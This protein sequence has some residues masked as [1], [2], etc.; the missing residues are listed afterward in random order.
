[1]PRLDR[2]ERAAYMQKYNMKKT[3]EK[4]ELKPPPPPKQPPPPCPTPNFNY[5]AWRQCLVTV[6]MW[7]A[8]E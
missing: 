7:A 8:R 4:Q 6:T 2:E 3:V 5:D 1:M